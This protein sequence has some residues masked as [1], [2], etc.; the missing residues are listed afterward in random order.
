MAREIE[1][2][3]LVRHEGW[4]PHV[5]RLARIEQAYL[6]ASP[7]LSMRVRIRDGKAATL[8]IKSAAKELDRAEFEYAIPLE[9][10]RELIE[11]AAAPVLEKTRHDVALGGLKWEVDVFAGRHAG[12]VIA[13][14][15][16]P[17]AGHELALP[18]WLGEEV[19]GNPDFYNEHLA[20][21]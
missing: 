11:L 8:T 17:A 12:L 14:V 16:L 10:A 1:R 3:F 2:K 9:D 5:V 19:T 4:R 6:G 20:R 7:N 15:E 18:D 21:V 13:E